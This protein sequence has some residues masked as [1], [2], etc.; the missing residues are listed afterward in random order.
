M[1]E[2]RKKIIAG[3]GIAGLA[4]ALYFGNNKEAEPGNRII[5]G[6]GGAVLAA[7]CLYQLIRKENNSEGGSTNNQ[8][9]TGPLQPQTPRN[10]S[11]TDARQIHDNRHDN[12]QDNRQIHIHHHYHPRNPNP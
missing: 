3:L 2:L 10:L 12:R 5:Y 7:V 11:Y 8:H 6:G 1:V 9:P 4:S